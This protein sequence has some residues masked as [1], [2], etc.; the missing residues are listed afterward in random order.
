M[1]E[2][3][4]DEQKYEKTYKE[5]CKDKKAFIEKVVFGMLWD[6]GFSDINPIE[7][8]KLLKDINGL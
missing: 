4:S 2:L 5:Y 1:K 6:K 7:A 8:L 3:M